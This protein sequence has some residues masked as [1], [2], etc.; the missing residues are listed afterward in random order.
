MAKEGQLQANGVLSLSLG[1]AG[2]VRVEQGPG[3]LSEPQL[4]PLS[5]GS[6]RPGQEEH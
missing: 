1:S 3:P 4:S 5:S 6:A 2:S